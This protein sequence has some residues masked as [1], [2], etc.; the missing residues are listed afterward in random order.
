M[1]FNNILCFRVP[2]LRFSLAFSIAS[3]YISSARTAQKT[4]LPTLFYCFDHVTGVIHCIAM[5][6]FA[7]PFPSN[8]CLLVSHFWLSADILGLPGSRLPIG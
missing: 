1:D 4:P 6:V 8:G 7:E 5:G 2:R 3:S